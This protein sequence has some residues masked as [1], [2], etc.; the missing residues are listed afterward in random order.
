MSPH[1]LAACPNEID[2]IGLD[3]VCAGAV[4][5]VEDVSLAVAGGGLDNFVKPP[6]ESPRNNV[7][8]A[9]KLP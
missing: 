2:W 8:V 7:V 6:V 9:F 1:V 4:A 3:G 5:A